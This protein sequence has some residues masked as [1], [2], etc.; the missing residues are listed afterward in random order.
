MELH[1]K[2]LL[3]LMLLQEVYSYFS[4][5]LPAIQLFISTSPLHISVFTGNMLIT[6][7]TIT[8]AHYYLLLASNSIFMADSL[9]LST[10]QIWQ[11]FNEYYC[12][13]ISIKSV[14]WHKRHKLFSIPVTEY[15]SFSH[16]ARML[17]INLFRFNIK[18]F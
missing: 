5:H 17:K 2:S 16:Q 11:N 13:S 9:Y 15:I 3:L 12:C 4:F 8:F 14:I 18:F 10:F 6:I 1:H 7:I